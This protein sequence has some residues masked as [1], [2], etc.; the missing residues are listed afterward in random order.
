MPLLYGVFW[1]E[2]FVLVSVFVS[3]CHCHPDTRYIGVLFVVHVDVCGVWDVVLLYVFL[4]GCPFVTSL[5]VCV[6]VCG[7]RNVSC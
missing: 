5:H 7:V 2:L 4:I 6:D 1:G 3:L